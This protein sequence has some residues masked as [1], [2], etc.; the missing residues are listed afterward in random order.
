MSSANLKRTPL[1][2]RHVEAGAKMVPFAGW[3]MPVQFSGLIIEH[4]AVRKSVGI[5]DVCHMGEVLCQGPQAEAALEYMT[6][7]NVSAIREGQAQYNAIINP[8]GGVVDDIIIYKKSKE[9]FFIC[10][11]ASNTEKDFNWFKEH[12]DFNAKFVNESHNFG[13]IAVQGPNAPKIMDKVVGKSISANVMYFNFCEDKIASIPVMIARTGYTGEDGFEVFIPVE[14]TGEIWDLF[15]EVGKEF[16]LCPGG[17]GARDTLR[18]EACYPLHGHEL[19]DDIT[20]I[21]SGLGWIVK[22]EKGDF[23]GSSILTEQKTKGA[24]RSLVGFLV[25]DAGIVREHSPLF[26][27]AGD[28]IGHVTS[29]TKTPSVNKAL[30]MALVKSGFRDVGT[31]FLAEVRGR[32]IKCE[33]VKRPFYKTSAPPPTLK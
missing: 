19:G 3:E 26:S 28:E 20:A 7:N 25:E 33:V 18:L 32:R 21:E 2:Q 29:G 12:N 9:D 5:F 15:F 22:P 14:S 13:Q 30:G 24:P 10:V 27:S 4:L 1:F 16:G 6:C 17:L 31:E 23:V 8:Q 11:N